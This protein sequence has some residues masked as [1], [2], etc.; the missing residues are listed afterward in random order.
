LFKL[1]DHPHRAEQML[2]KK[3]QAR[4]SSQ[5]RSLPMTITINSP[6]RP[7]LDERA[8]HVSPRSIDRD[9]APLV[10]ELYTSFQ[11]KCT[12]PRPLE[13]FLEWIAAQ[14]ELD[15]PQPIINVSWELVDIPEKPPRCHHQDECMHYEADYS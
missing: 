6:I 10:K 14:L 15:N 7:N 1:V 9:C 8:N 12:S 13:P 2:D 3:G 4:T 11:V 5:E